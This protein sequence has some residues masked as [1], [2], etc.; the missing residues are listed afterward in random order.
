MPSR[1]RG[2]AALDA[3]HERDKHRKN[4]CH[5]AL[6]P[7]RRAYADRVPHHEPEIEGAGM[8][9]EPLENVLMPPQMRAPHAPRVVEVREGA[10]DA[11]TALV[12]TCT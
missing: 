4:D 12:S 3:R 9:Q 11:F 10:L 7:P 2:Q 6:E 8:N 5:A 1:H